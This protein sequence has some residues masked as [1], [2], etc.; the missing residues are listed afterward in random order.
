MY[1]RR[2]PPFGRS[3]GNGHWV[4]ASDGSVDTFLASWRGLAR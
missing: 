4:M 2:E 3:F 1:L